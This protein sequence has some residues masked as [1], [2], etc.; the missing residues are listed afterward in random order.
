[1]GADDG[2]LVLGM[3]RVR[4]IAAVRRIVAGWKRRGDSVAFVPTMGAI[5]DGHEGLMRR[6]RARSKR[7]VVSI[8]VN[9][10]QFGPGED[11]RRYPRPIARDR[12]RIAE[13]GA[14]LLWEPGVADLYDDPDRTRVRVQGLDRGLEGASR[15]GHFEGVATVV[16]KL[17]NAVLPD[18]LWLGQ[19]DAQQA[20]LL[21]QMIA[22]LRLP[23]RVRRGR[24]VREPDGLACSSRNA[25]L[26][27]EE[28]AQAVALY[29]GLMV[30]RRALQGGE[31][32][33]RG[34]VARVRRAWRAYP[35]VREEYV[36][37]VDA[38]SLEP[39]RSV[40]RRT[41]V[42]VAARVGRTRLI[43]NFEWEPR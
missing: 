5:H 32:S 33:A 43:D 4:G 3:K 27:R 25:Y 18:V 2:R 6:A 11:F 29:L 13:V 8:F 36:A 34:I 22:D 9:P 12:R 39:V 31:R 24:T 16:T 21:E 14:D 30:A 41:L 20:R 40:E 26:S 15:P 1:M 17:L 19:K 42:A 37:V 38:K 35:R 23:V 7:L 10:L 28:R